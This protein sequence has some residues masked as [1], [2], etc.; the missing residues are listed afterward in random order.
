MGETFKGIIKALI[1]N[2]TNFNSKRMVVTILFMVLSYKL[3]TFSVPTSFK[4]L[5]DPVL[6]Y[7]GLGAALAYW[8]KKESEVPTSLEVG[9]KM[10]GYLK[11]KSNT[12]TGTENDKEGRPTS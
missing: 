11:D 5:I 3:L 12:A 10:N 4:P 8:M 6:V 9:E 2:I 1:V 7:G